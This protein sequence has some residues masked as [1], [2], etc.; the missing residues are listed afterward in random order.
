MTFVDAKHAATLVVDD[1]KR[2]AIVA[3]L[4]P[5]TVGAELLAEARTRDEESEPPNYVPPNRSMDKDSE[6]ARFTVHGIH[7]NEGQRFVIDAAGSQL[8]DQ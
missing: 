1:D 8:S 7:A 3:M 2:V 5:W 6:S 4:Q